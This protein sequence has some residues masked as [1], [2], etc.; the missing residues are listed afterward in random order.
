MCATVGVAPFLPARLVSL[1]LPRSARRERLTTYLSGLLPVYVVNEYRISEARISKVIGGFH[2]AEAFTMTTDSRQPQSSAFH[3]SMSEFWS[4][5]LGLT[6]VTLSVTILAFVISPLR[7]A[8]LS[9]RVFFDLIVLA[10]MIYAAIAANSTR[11]F[12]ACL[13]V[14]VSATSVVLAAGRLHPTP[15]LH[16]SGSAFVTITLLLYFRIVLL[17]MFRAGRVTWSRI[18]GGVCAY[19]L[20]GMA[21]ASAFQF[22]EQLRPGSLRFVSAATDLDQLTSKI[23]YFSFA[24]LTT[25]GSDIIPVSPFARSLTTAEAVVGQ[26]FPAILIGALVAMAMQPRHNS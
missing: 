23:T 18:Q 24:T 5:D 25:M 19:L 1:F 17:V 15:F 7:E 12:K 13:I 6:L 9:A 2:L 16:L 22:L 11:I 10:L 3:L 8:G 21:W 4:G 14:T 26:L 20:L